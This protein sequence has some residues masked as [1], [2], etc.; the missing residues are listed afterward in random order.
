MSGGN[1]NGAGNGSGASW[2]ESPFDHN[3]GW[4]N[5]DHALG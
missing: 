5:G 2:G 1:G 4:T 3:R